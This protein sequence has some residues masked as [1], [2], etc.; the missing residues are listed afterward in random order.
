MTSIRRTINRIVKDMIAGFIGG[1]LISTG[2]ISLFGLP[3]VIE[4]LLMNPEYEQQLL[5]LQIWVV[6]V[7]S[8][9]TVLVGSIFYD[10]KRDNY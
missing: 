9:I 8:F 7:I 1:C 5:F 4:I 6:C 3:V 2:G 10:I